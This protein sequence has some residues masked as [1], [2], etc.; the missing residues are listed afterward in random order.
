MPVSFRVVCIPCK[1]LYKCSALPLP[2]PG[3]GEF[4]VFTPAEA[5]TRFSD[6]EGCKTESTQVI[7]LLCIITSTKYLP[8]DHRLPVLTQDQNAVSV[9]WCTGTVSALR[10]PRHRGNSQPAECEWPV[11]C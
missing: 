9:E 5:G 2:L 4:P 6:P 8:Y 3:S 10:L 7:E 1:A 11:V